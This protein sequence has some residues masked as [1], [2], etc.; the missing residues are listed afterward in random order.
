MPN[1]SPYANY[2]YLGLIPEAAEATPLTPTTFVGIQNESIVPSFGIKSIQTIAGNRERNVRSVPDKV[3]IGGDVEFYLEPKTI[4]HFLRSL[5]GAPVSQTLTA[6]TAFRH[7]FQVS[8]TPKTYTIDI[9]PA[10]APWIHRYYGVHMSQLEFTQGDNVIVCKASLMPRKA[11]INARILTSANSGVA[12]AL[13][14][15]SG[16]V[17]GDSILIIQKENGFTTVQDREIATIVDENNITVT[18][19]LDATIDVDDIVVIKRQT[20]TYDQDLELTFF[21]G[22]EIYTGDDIDNTTA[23]DKEDYSITFGN[24]LEP[25]WFAGCNEVDRYPGDILT[26]G[27]TAAATINKFYDSESKLDI[28]RKNEQFALRYLFCGETAIEANV[29]VK[30]SS[31]W[32]ATANGFKVA[33]TTAGK[34]GND[35]NISIAVNTI[36]TLAASLSGKNILVQLAMTTAASNTGTLVAAAI[37]ALAGVDGTAEGTGA[38]EFTVAEANQNLGFR[39]TSAGAEA[40]TNVVGR[41]AS[42][43][44]SLQTDFSACKIEPYFPNAS[45]DS[46]LEEAITVAVYKDSVSGDQKKVWS[47]RLFLVNDVASY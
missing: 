45:E 28:A 39:V 35:Y 38:E 16:L 11:F 22:T 47:T 18:A 26:K 7:V 10:D 34:A 25:R 23:E 27:Y 31:T 33:A 13:D 12:V 17:V 4:G 36:D 37:N 29:A 43:V 3:E 40:G 14:Q 24:E 6:A 41:D 15:T 8:D 44:P 19:A 5:F 46:V 9:Q 42:E 20:A 32:G 30:A 1:F 2:G 21:G